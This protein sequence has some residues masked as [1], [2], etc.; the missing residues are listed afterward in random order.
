MAPEALRAWTGAF[1]RHLPERRPLALLDLGCGT[2]RLT[3]ALA[4]AF[5]GSA[6]GIEPSRMMLRHAVADAAHPRVGY[7]T[8]SAE[9]IPLAAG[10]A[11]AALLFFVWHHVADKQAAAAELHRVVRPG[12]R[13]L[14]RTN[15]SDRMPDLWWYRWLPGAALADQRM[16]RPLDAVVADFTGAGWSW[17]TVDEV[18]V[19]QAVSIREDFAR[20]RT[21]ALSTFEHLPGDEVERGFGDIEAALP[22]I[23]DAPVPS[24]GDLLVFTH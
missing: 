8:G 17:R 13:L 23:G 12:G 15:C 4:D 16:Y 6:V 9:A 21:R 10:S 22:T 11:D 7:L 18:A 5:G 24:R 14:V 2:G 1:A 19:T 20:L 3:P